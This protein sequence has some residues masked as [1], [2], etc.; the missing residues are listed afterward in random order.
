[1]RLYKKR[2]SPTDYCGVILKSCTIKDHYPFIEL[3]R[4]KH[5]TKVQIRQDGLIYVL[6]RKN[7]RYY[8]AATLYT[9]EWNNEYL[10]VEN[11][12]QKPQMGYKDYWEVLE[13]RNSV[14][15]ATLMGSLIRGEDGEYTEGERMPINPKFVEKRVDSEI[16]NVF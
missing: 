12:M 6:A 15:I 13:F 1:M 8:I 9:M 2:R 11:L 14:Y 5:A 4:R 3:M 7:R 10:S 16:I